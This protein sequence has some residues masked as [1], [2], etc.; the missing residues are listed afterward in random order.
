MMKLNQSPS[1]LTAALIKFAII[2]AIGASLF[3]NHQLHAAKK[4]KV[5]MVTQ[6][7]GFVHG[8]VNRKENK[9]SAAEI[10]M[11]QLGQQ[12]GLFE[13]HCTQDCESDFTIENLKNYDLVMLYTTGF[14]PIPKKARKYF[15]ETWLK[16]KGHGLIGFHSAT[17]TYGANSENCKW[18][19]EI[20]GGTFNGHPWNS[21]NLV[22]ISVHD[23]SHPAMKPLGSEFQIKD[24]IYQYKNWVPENV[25]VLMSLNMAK[26]KPSKPYHVP[27]AWTREWGEGKIYYNNLGH[28]EETWTNKTF[29]KS[30]EGAI[31]WVMNLESADVTPNPELS[32]SEE[33]KAAKDANG[34]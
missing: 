14:L 34:K 9:L 8:T 6:S 24:E 10:A 13:V 7:A 30:T 4:T 22:T 33:A 28:N 29:L 11:T 18:Y 17:D 2:F 5:L 20:I 1:S 31:R 23:S 21:K 16:E 15:A 12:T 25:H 27:V 3:S 26:C 32:K 19:Q